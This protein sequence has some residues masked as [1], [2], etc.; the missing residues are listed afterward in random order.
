MTTF[1]EGFITMRR[2]GA[3]GRRHGTQAEKAPPYVG[4]VPEEVEGPPPKV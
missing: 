3:E 4:S 1:H 2:E